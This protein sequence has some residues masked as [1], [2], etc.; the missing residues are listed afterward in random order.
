MA[1]EPVASTELV[2]E[3]DYASAL[4]RHIPLLLDLDRHDFKRGSAWTV[5]PP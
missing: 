5:F 3:P 4:Q 2:V 1:N